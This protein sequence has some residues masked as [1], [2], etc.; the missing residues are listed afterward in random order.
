MP[1]YVLVCDLHLDEDGEVNRVTKT[2][3]R[4]AGFVD[5]KCPICKVPMTRE[6]E[7]PTSRVVEVLDSGL[8]SRRVERPADAERLYKERADKD[9][10]DKGF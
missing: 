8:M 3:I 5:V 6:S 10:K 7:A 9:N 1:K 2:V 4:N